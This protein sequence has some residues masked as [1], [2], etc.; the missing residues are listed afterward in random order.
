MKN[1][2]PPAEK[3][4]RRFG[5]FDFKRRGPPAPQPIGTKDPAPPAEPQDIETVDVANTTGG[6]LT[7]GSTLGEISQTA[8][9]REGNKL[10]GQRCQAP[11]GD[12]ICGTVLSRHNPHSIPI[13]Q[14]CAGR[15][16]VESLHRGECP[17]IE[18]IW[19]RLETKRRAKEKTDEMA[20]RPS[21]VHETVPVSQPRPL[22]AG[23]G[24]P[25]KA[26]VA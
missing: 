9:K 25:P 10:A 12:G 17:D 7:A 5:Q 6:Q 22:A 19:R 20:S 13:C 21:G 15:L 23:G 26:S 4:Q 3:T 24:K 11:K 8:Q 1:G 18:K 2:G 16:A 14:P